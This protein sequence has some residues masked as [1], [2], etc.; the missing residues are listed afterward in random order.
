MSHN[1]PLPYQ[2]IIKLS[3]TKVR[4]RGSRLVFARDTSITY[5]GITARFDILNLVNISPGVI[6]LGHIEKHV[7]LNI[8]G[9]H[10]CLYLL[11]VVV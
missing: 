6:F 1:I 7:V 4:D 11:L 3:F 9:P 10:M 2:G 8:Q 5:G